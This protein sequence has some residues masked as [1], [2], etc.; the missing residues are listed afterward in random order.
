MKNKALK[1]HFDEIYNSNRI[2]KKDLDVVLQKFKLIGE[3]GI[4]SHSIF[5]VLNLNTTKY[6]FMTSACESFTGIAQDKFYEQGLQLLP[7]FI[8]PDDLILLSESLFP[9]MNSFTKD[10][11]VKDKFEIIFELYYNMKNAETGEIFPVVEFSSYTK[12]DNIGNPVLSTGI[13]Y[14]QEN[15]INGVKGVV[16]LNKDAEQQILFNETISKK[17]KV[18]T[19]SEFKIAQLLK[20]GYSRSL[21]AE[22]LNISNHTVNTHIKKIYK[23]YNVNKVSELL[24]KL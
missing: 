4:N 12:F 19:K 8:V 7:K 21:I 15:Y 14:R 23:K 11:S 13:C 10:L 6:E 1:R 17:S 2:T 20:K 18:L 16:R 22:T 3:T 24:G 9:K 5:Y